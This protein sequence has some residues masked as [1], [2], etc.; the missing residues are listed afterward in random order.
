MCVRVLRNCRSGIV[1][2]RFS[3]VFK[4]IYVAL[5]LHV[6]VVPGSFDSRDWAFSGGYPTVQRG[7]LS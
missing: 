5:Q 4:E 2:P 3:F 1:S 6:H 7:C